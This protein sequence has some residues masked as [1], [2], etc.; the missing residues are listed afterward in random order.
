M[1]L[2][3]KQDGLTSISHFR[4]IS[5]CNSIYKILS[6]ILVHILRHLIPALVSPLQS[7]FMVGKRSS[8]NVII[9]QELI[10]SLKRRKG[11]EGFMVIKINLEKVYDRLEWSFIRMVLDH[12]GFPKN[13]SELILSCV[14]TTSTSLLFNGSKLEAFSPS[15]GIRQ[16]D[17]ISPYIFLLCIKYMSSLITK[18]CESKEWT[19]VKASQVAQGSLMFS[20]QMTFFYLLR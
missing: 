2:I 13:F 17:P 5:L 7:A 20:L 14:S 3:P 8:D 10:H 11:R 12:F 6:K 15:R 19:V 18:S 4:P 16:G 1:T 9:A